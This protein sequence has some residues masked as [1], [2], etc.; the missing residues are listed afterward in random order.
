[1]QCII[2]VC[3][4]KKRKHLNCPNYV[5]PSDEP[6]LP[7]FSTPRPPPPLPDEQPWQSAQQQLAG[8]EPAS[9]GWQDEPRRRQPV[10]QL[11]RPRRR[12]LLVQPELPVAHVHPRHSSHSKQPQVRHRRSLT[13]LLNTL[14]ALLA[15]QTTTGTTQT[16]FN[17]TPKYTPGTP[18]TPNNHRYDTHVL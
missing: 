3:F 18:R 8:E 9:P 4:D 14:L 6:Q 16:F 10:G 1:M 12:R 7:R 17:I 11:R 2:N 5:L 13:S 15:L